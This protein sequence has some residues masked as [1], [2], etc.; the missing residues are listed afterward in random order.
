MTC[1]LG[2]RESSELSDDTGNTYDNRQE[3]LG[4]LLGAFAAEIASAA[5][6]LSAVLSAWASL[7]DA[8]KAGIIAMV[9]AAA[10]NRQPG[11]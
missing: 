6:D 11:A 1:G 4:V 9:K 10:P 2:N 5:P 7:P 3:E 8:L